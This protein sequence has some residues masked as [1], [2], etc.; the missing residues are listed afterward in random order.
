VHVSGTS[1]DACLLC[2]PQILDIMLKRHSLVTVS[3]DDA[4]RLHDTDV[5]AALF[6]DDDDEEEEDDD[7]DND[8]GVD[9]DDDDDHDNDDTD[10]ADESG[11]ESHGAATR[12]SG[13]GGADGGLPL[14]GA[15]DEDASSATV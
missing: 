7:N 2:R 6:D 10:K 5:D 13:D 14:D 11:T 1:H 4:P 8:G 15:T 9:D 3:F 12:H